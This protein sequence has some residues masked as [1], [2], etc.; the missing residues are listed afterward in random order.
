MALGPTL[1]GL[2]T[3]YLSWN[4]IFYINVPVGIVTL[5]EDLQVSDRE[6]YR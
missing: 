1:G 4:W 6:P 2:L 3:E 5:S